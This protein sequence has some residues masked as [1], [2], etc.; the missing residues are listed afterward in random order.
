ML[1]R[2]SGLRS[3]GAGR[4]GCALLV[5]WQGTAEWWTTRTSICITD[6]GKYE[7]I[8]SKGVVIGEAIFAAD[9]E[10]DTEVYKDN[11]QDMAGRVQDE[12]A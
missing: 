4:R 6:P 7:V 11:R 3:G 9:A 1:R 5:R 12:T 8:N 10:I 2:G